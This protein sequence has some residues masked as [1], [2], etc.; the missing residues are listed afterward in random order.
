MA[1]TIEPLGNGLLPTALSA[2]YGAAMGLRNRAF[3]TFSNLSHDIDRPVISI[4]GVAAGGSGKT[5][6]ALV[7]GRYA[8]SKGYAVAF[9]S[10]GYRR[11][12]AQTVISAPGSLDSWES[13]GDE[14]AMLHSALPQTWLGIGA[15]RIR[16]AEALVPQLPEKAVFVLDDAFQHRKVK[17]NLDIVCL[18]P[19]AHR[20]RL[21]PAGMLRESLAGLR[22]AQCICIV[23]S[24]DDDAAGMAES[25]L[26]LTSRFPHAAVVSL[27]QRAAGWVNVK[28]GEHREVLP[29]KRPAAL[30]GIAR[31]QRFIILLKKMGI[32]LYAKSIF[33]DH[34]AFTGK[35]IES[36][37]NS[38][39]VSGIVTTEKDAVRLRSLKLVSWPDIWYLKIEVLFSDENSLSHFNRVIDG[40]LP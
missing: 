21:L 5:P 10:R 40:I 20:D 6:L 23:G 12:A 16:C 39:G 11:K 24:A 22:R 33:N 36:I 15:D 27:N 38:P 17:R 18:P 19:G 35:E 29:I 2:L 4:G 30:C 34:H 3:D 32:S 25:R 26:Y 31:P 28:T 8:L 9:L 1:R 37:A 14:P 13:V 7:T